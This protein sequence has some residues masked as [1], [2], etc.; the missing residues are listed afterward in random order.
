MAHSAVLKEF[1]MKAKCLGQQ[2]PLS[3][4][5]CI[6]SFGQHDLIIKLSCNS[7][8]DSFSTYCVATEVISFY[9][10]YS[11]LSTRHFINE[12]SKIRVN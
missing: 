7:S 3:C 2:L 9:L 12:N 8:K 1:G 10:P 11:I 4:V 6:F 5:L